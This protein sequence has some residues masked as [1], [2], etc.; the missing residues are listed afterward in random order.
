M[1][2]CSHVPAGVLECQDRAATVLVIGKKGAG[3]IEGRR[4]RK[5]RGA[6]ICPFQR[7]R[8]RQTT[9]GTGRAVQESERAPAAGAESAVRSRRTAANAEW[10]KQKV[11]CGF[12]GGN[13]LV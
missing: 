10:W 1:P 7:H 4:T 9:T 11:E 8:K 12:G 13:G 5:T 6:K 3:T 2:A